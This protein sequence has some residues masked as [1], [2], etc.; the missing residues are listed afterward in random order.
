[1][2]FVPSSVGVLSILS[3]HPG[4]TA[5]CTV[6]WIFNTVHIGEHFSSL[7]IST[8]CMLPI[9]QPRPSS[10]RSSETQIMYLNHHLGCHVPP[11]SLHVSVPAHDGPVVRLTMIVLNQFLPLALSQFT[12]GHL[13]QKV[14]RVTNQP[15]ICT[16]RSHAETDQAPVRNVDCYGGLQARGYV[17]VCTCVCV[18]V[19]VCVCLGD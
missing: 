15:E 3:E 12:T 11:S 7:Q 9:E 19:C 2:L 17:Y 6:K 13:L 5:D 14:N 18:C 4:L 10:R 8:P 16:S 1:M